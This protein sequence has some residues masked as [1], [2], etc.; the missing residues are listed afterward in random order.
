MTAKRS[1]W[2]TTASRLL[3]QKELLCQGGC[4][5]N[6]WMHPIL[7]DRRTPMEAASRYAIRAGPRKVVTRISGRGRYEFTVQ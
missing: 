7:P 1:Q 6:D 2:L 3:Q 4:V 5:R